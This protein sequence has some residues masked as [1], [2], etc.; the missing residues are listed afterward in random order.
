[1]MVLS[2]LLVV[3]GIGLLAVGI[4]ATMVK[5]PG[6]NWIRLRLQET[7]KTREMWNTGHRI[8][9]PPW[10]GAGI[11][12]VAAGAVSLRG[13]W[14][15]AIAGLLIVGA[16]FL[17]GLGAALAAQALAKIDHAKAQDVEAARQ[18]GSCSVSGVVV[19]TGHSLGRVS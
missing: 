6:N 4:L 7:R 15:W 9:G 17:I 2:V 11:A 10:V 18:S 1:M 12:L 19:D 13:G 8:A 5:L 3:F 14:L 16:L